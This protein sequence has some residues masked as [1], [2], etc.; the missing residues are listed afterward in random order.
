MSFSFISPSKQA[1]LLLTDKITTTSDKENI[2][3]FGEFFYY[4]RQEIK[5]EK[6]NDIQSLQKEYEFT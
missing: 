6:V 3:L 2:S 4:L 5:K 1:L